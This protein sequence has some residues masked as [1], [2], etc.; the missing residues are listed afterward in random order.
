MLLTEVTVLEQILRISIFKIGNLVVQFSDSFHKS[1]L[2]TW[3]LWRI[4]Y[5]PE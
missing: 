1:P 2:W 4:T 3:L 5:L